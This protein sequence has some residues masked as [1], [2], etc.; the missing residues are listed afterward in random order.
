M[1]IFLTL[2]TWS[3]VLFLHQY[4]CINIILYLVCRFGCWLCD[5][6][7]VWNCFSYLVV[8]EYRRSSHVVIICIISFDTCREMVWIVWL[9]FITLLLKK[10]DHYLGFFYHIIISLHAIFLL[11]LSF[12]ILYIMDI[13]IVLMAKHLGNYNIL[14]IKDYIL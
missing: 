10:I 13:I 2:D 1:L 11:R 12:V 4:S 8:I 14:M 3:V 9:L 5:K 7:R 6:S